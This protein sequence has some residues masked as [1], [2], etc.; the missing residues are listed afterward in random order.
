MKA[1]AI[2]P[3]VANSARVIDTPEPHMNNDQVMVRMVRGGICGTDAEI[4]TGAFGDAPPGCDYL[5]LGHE[6]FGQ[7]ERVG[8]RTSRFK[9]GD[10]VVATVRRPCD[11]INCEAG[12]SD[13]CMTEKFTERGV[14]REHGFLAEYYADYETFL[15][16]IPAHLHEVAILIEPYSIVSKA[17]WQGWKIQERMVWQPRTALVTGAGTIGLLAALALRARG[18]KVVICGLAGADSL[19]AK[20]A[21]EAGATYVCVNDTP[22]QEIPKLLGNRIDVLFEATGH[23]PTSL[24]ALDLITTNG[25]ALLVSVTIGTHKVTVDADA[26]NMRMVLGNMLAVGLVNANRKYFEF[27]VRDFGNFQERFPGVLERM[28]TRRV[29]LNDFTTQLFERNGVKTTIEIHPR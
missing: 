12:E 5:I 29:P 21:T 19:S 27:G 23:G 10:Y 14:R 17:I 28:L 1:I 4:N 25:I 18:L 20:L 2:T 11:C 24:Q 3:H 15:V 16:P 13:M 6:N 8:S 9:K 22:L 7:V 26:L